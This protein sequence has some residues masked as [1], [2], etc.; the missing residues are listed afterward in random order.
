MKKIILILI[1]ISPISIAREKGQIEITTNQGIE[2]FQNEKYY[3]LKDNVNIVSDDFELNADLVKAYFEKDLYDISK[4]EATG[5]AKLS[6]IKNIAAIG[7]KIYFSINDQQIQVEGENSNLNFNNL[8]MFSNKLILV[9]NIKKNFILK[10]KSSILKT[11]EIKIVA[12]LIT[13]KY[14][15]INDVNEIK[16]LDIKDENQ[17]SITTKTAKMFSKKAK[18]NKKN[19]IIELFENVKIIRVNEIVE[20]EY[21]YIDLINESYKVSSKNNK[22]VKLLID[23]KTNE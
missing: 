15:N 17:L 9:D 18:F 23:N 4:I 16:E 13:G 22:K 3:L 14:I 8:D 20:A 2:V 5:N 12:S 10:G 7:Q 21:A 6:S 19:D 11:E 1:F